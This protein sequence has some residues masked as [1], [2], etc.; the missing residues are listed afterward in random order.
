MRR[1]P[2]SASSAQQRT[3]S[4]KRAWRMVAPVEVEMIDTTRS[5]PISPAMARLDPSS[6]KATIPAD[7]PCGSSIV[8]EA[9]GISVEPGPPHRTANSLTLEAIPTASS[10]PSREMDSEAVCA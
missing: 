2:P 8:L 5:C 10:A 1:R 4:S 7:T 6:E 9:C 3:R